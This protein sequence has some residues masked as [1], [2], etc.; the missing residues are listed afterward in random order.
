[1]F[2]SRPFHTVVVGGGLAGMAAAVALESAGHRVTLLEARKRLGGRAGSFVD[3]GTGEE[4]DNCQHVLLGCCTNLIDFYRRVGV[5]DRIDW[6]E[7]YYFRDGLGRRHDLYGL[8]GLP[9]PLHLG[10]SLLNFGLLTLTEKAALARAML[11]MATTDLASVAELPFGVWLDR[12][13]Q[14]ASL[15]KKVY[16]P[17]VI[18]GLNE[19]TRRVSSAYAI[20]IFKTALLANRGAY[21]VGT[22]GCTLSEL[23][24][25][26]ELEGL[27]TS[28]RVVGLV[29]EEEAENRVVGVQL[30]TGECVEADHVVL[31]TGFA[32]A[33]KWAEGDP[34]FARVDGLEYVPILGAHL[35][36][37]RPVLREPHA[38]F[39]EP[40]LQWVFRKNAEGSAVHAVISAARE[41]VGRDE[42]EMLA[43]FEGQIRAQLP[44]AE[45]AKIVRSRIVI[46]KRATFSPVPGVDGLRPVQ[47][48]VMGSARNL[49]LAG[50]YTQTGWPATMEGA[51]RSGYL[52]AEAITGRRFLVED[53]P[54]EW[55]A[56]VLGL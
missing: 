56:V 4:L 50:D 8:S 15:V 1:M 31:A 5:E 6:S 54:V 10:P 29:M 49:Y 14:P 12:H 42:G 21:A 23:Y 16:D 33:M 41:F 45:G 22:P 11:A 51:V 7:C 38:A 18:S 46:E 13:G 26:L 34:R 30:A 2:H 44:G 3:A 25:V 47:A 37:D 39:I 52:A 40:P 17:V 48:P 20:Q 24:D 35:W 28:A 53:L 27:R 32:T 19:Q 36:F 9:A 43:E 55:P